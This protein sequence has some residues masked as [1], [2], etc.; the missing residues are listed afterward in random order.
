[1]AHAGAFKLRHDVTRARAAGPITRSDAIGI[2]VEKLPYRVLSTDILI[3]GVGWVEITA[4]IRLKD[5]QR[6]PQN[7]ELPPPRIQAEP[8]KPKD[9]FAAMESLIVDGRGGKKQTLAPAREVRRPE[10]REAQGSPSSTGP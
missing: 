2:K 9:P 3:E 4:Q 10:P 1:M 5:L 7:T 8:V 6:P